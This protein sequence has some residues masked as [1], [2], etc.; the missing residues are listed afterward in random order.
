[1]ATEE[2]GEGAGE[3]MEKRQFDNPLG[4]ALYR[5]NLPEQRPGLQGV[6]HTGI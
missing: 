2:C 4:D 3:L 1:M 6:A 5:V